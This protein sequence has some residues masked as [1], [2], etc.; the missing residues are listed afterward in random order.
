[1]TKRQNKGPGLSLFKKECLKEDI[2]AASSFAGG[3]PSILAQIGH[4]DIHISPANCNFVS[5]P[6]LANLLR[7]LQ[8]YKSDK[9]RKENNI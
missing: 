3:F 8:C 5:F 9:K 1:M 6:L 4:F 2:G 7:P